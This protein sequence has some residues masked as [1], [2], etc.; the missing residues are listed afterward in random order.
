MDMLHAR[1]F[2]LNLVLC[3][4]TRAMA[5]TETRLPFHHRLHQ[6]NEPASSR[7]PAAGKT[8]PFREFMHT[9]Q[10]AHALTHQSLPVRWICTGMLRRKKSR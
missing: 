7:P 2:Y 3:H 6:G 8:C 1:P 4:R 9:R 5:Y 10:H